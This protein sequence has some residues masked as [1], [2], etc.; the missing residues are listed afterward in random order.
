[1]TPDEH[2]PA[3]V[4]S[5][6][7]VPPIEGPAGGNALTRN[8]HGWVA[9]RQEQADGLLQQHRHRP[10]VDL[11]LRIVERDREAAGTVVGSAVAFRLFLFFV[12]LL[13]FIVGLA[14]FLS[15]LIEPEDIN[16]A[17]ITGSLATQI[18]TALEQQGSGRWIVVL[19]GLFGMATTGRTLSKA[20]VQVSCLNWRM[21][22]S[23]RAPARVIGGVVGLTVGIGLVSVIVNRIRQELGL[24]VMSVSFVVAFAAYA[25]AWILLSML[26]PRPTSDPG[27]LLPGAALVGLTV[28]VLQLVSQLYLPGRFERASQLYGAVGVTIVV[29]GWFFILGRVI[30]LSMTVNAAVY[31]RFGSISQFVFGLPVL[32]LLPRRWAWFRRFFQLEPDGPGSDGGTAG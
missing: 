1:V 7:Q 31:E 12:P 32:R 9:A 16:E 21:P 20:L 6:V 4:P 19:I 29:L 15:T 17:G 3:D 22:V 13:L 11:A 28:T 10:L 24:G 23:K 18:E 2:R 26:L 25:L 5:E 27:V 30:T 8:V 14:G